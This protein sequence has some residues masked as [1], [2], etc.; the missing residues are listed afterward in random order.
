M[1]KWFGIVNHVPHTKVAAFA[2]HLREGRIM[3]SRCQAC[4]HR[5]FPPRA[6]CEQCLHG[7]FELVEVSGRCTLLSWTR[8]TAA[9]SGFEA[10]APYTLGVVD[11]EEGGR[12]LAPFGAA[13]P[14]EALAMGMALH[15]VPRLHEDRE[16]IKVD[17]TLEPPAAGGGGKR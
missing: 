10:L 16:D 3:G 1:F 13:L 7:E 2:Q 17:Y 8:I 9:P 5:T 12:A 4:G 11:L 15:L 14:D 6:D